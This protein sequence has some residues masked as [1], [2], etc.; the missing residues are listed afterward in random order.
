LGRGAA[1]TLQF[2]QSP[3]GLET[4]RPPLAALSTTGLH[5]TETILLVEDDDRV[6]G[7]AATV[8][9]T[10][11]YDVLEASRPAAALQMAQSRDAAIHLLLSDVIMPGFDGVELMKRFRVSHPD[12]PVLFMSGYSDEA[13]MRHGL[14]VDQYELLTKPF[15][16]AHLLRKVREV[17]TV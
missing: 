1:F 3:A 6:R 12:T 4:P 9:K 10:A 17:L 15:S 16:R 7:F 2:P 8:L 5:G 13:M 11:G 14:T